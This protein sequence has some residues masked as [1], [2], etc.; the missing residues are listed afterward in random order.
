MKTG[1]EVDER[2]RI[3]RTKKSNK[4]ATS[5]QGGEK[6]LCNK[7]TSLFCHEPNRRV[8]FNDKPQVSTGILHTSDRY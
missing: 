4:S 2:K 7:F 6:D 1:H 5:V 8:G 3:L